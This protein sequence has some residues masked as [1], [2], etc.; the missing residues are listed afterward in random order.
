MEW[1]QSRGSVP[2]RPA[3]PRSFPE[4][5]R[6][7][8]YDEEFAG[9]NAVKRNLPEPPEGGPSGR[10]L[11]VFCP[12][13]HPYWAEYEKGLRKEALKTGFPVAV[14]YA[15][16]DQ[17]VQNQAVQAAVDRRPDMIILIPVES[18]GAGD[19]IRYAHERSVPVI[20]SNQVLDNDLYPLIVAWTGP[21]DWGQHRLLAGKFAREVRRPGGYCIVTH[22]PG[23]SMHLARSRAAI[24]ELSEVA[25]DLRLL[26]MRFTGFNR[27]HTRRVVHEWIDRYGEELVGII[28]ADDSLPQEGI[29]RALAERG[30][31]DIV[32]VANGA[33]RRG[34]GF[35]RNGTLRAVTC[36]PPELDGAL[37]VKVAADWFRGLRVDPISYLPV[38]L[39][40]AE[41]VDSFLME[42]RG[43]ED[44]HGE[45]LCRMI[46]EGNLEEI[47]DFFEDFQRRLE[48]E[49]IVGE[50]YFGGL[51]IGLMG[52]LIYLA[53]SR[54]ID[55]V[56]LAGGY[57]MLYKGLFQQK[58]VAG[59]LE[60]LR[61]F[62]VGI[63]DRLMDMNLLSGSLDER[64]SAYIELHY[65]EPIALKSI[66]DHF[67]LSAAYLGKVF[68]E[69][70]GIS[71]SRYLNEYR[72]AKARELLASGNMKAK[73]VAVAVGY[74]D[75][76]Y[77]YS[78][79]RKLTG[80]PPSDF[81][82]S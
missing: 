42:G 23:T 56:E 14:H 64:L 47:G 65:T 35:V 22:R 27:E 55:P 68:K 31:E 66:S 45:E 76:N 20:V 18:S 36:Q 79:F 48:S 49:R 67:G 24:T 53:K 81:G 52:D 75:P 70:N 30:R 63:V 73:E 37:P 46:L 34:L 77:F 54:G 82:S 1:K 19:A 74:S 21:D 4:T 58:T 51:A 25:P 9:W 57:E 11:A 32:R 26:D 69:S 7:Y 59:S 71:F 50:E 12:G 38:S 3:D 61:S 5:D 39:I 62:S 17:E 16:S 41:N 28:S 43:V 40:T 8:W 72:I 2:P 60:W 29:N 6:R 10:R 15:D 44:F 78:I 33:T 13:T 80:R